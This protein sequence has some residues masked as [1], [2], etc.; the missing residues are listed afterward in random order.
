MPA[1]FIS[2]TAPPELFSCVSHPLAASFLKMTTG[3]LWCVIWLA[4]ANI[5]LLLMLTRISATTFVFLPILLFSNLLTLHLPSSFLLHAARS[6]NSWVSWLLSPNKCQL[7][8][9]LLVLCSDCTLST[10]GTVVGWWLW[11]RCGYCMRSN[12]SL[13]LT[14]MPLHK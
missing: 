7:C 13:F 10:P 1:K 12:L 3:W 11:F 14:E 9:L 5:L 2:F 4:Q 6:L 8:M